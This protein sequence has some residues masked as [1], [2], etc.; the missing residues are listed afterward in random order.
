MVGRIRNIGHSLVSKLILIVAA[1]LLVSIAT[2]S[3]YII[4]YQKQRV[5]EQTVAGVERLANTIRLGT[6]YAMMLNS[7]DD[8]NRIVHNIGLQREIES[9]RVF[10]KDGVIKFS[11]DRSEID[12]ATN[13]KAEACFVC[14]RTSPPRVEVPLD[15]RVRIFQSA[16]GYRLLGIVNPIYNDPACSADPCHVHPPE[17]KVLGAFDVVV[18]LEETDREILQ[19]EHRNLGLAFLVFLAAGTTVFLF[20]LRAVRAPLN[21]LIAGAKRM[22]AGDYTVEVD[23]RQMDEVGEMAT[24]FNHM[25]REIDQKQR[26]LNEQR[27]EYQNLFEQVPCLITVQ[28]RSYRIIKHN[29]LFADT[30]GP[31]PNDYCYHAYKGR[32]QKCDNCPV[33][34]T[35]M[36]GQPVY[37]EQDGVGKDGSPAHW[38][39]HSTPIFNAKGEIVAAMEMSLDITARKQLEDKLE[40]SEKKYHAIFNNIPN[41]VFVLDFDTFE[42]LDCNR[43]V[44]A[45]YDCSEHE[46]KHK[47]FLDLFQDDDKTVQAIQMKTRSVINQARHVNHDG[48]TIFVSI[49]QSVSESEGRKV[50]LVTTN[51]I[52]K[53]LEAEQQL[54]QAGKLAT[55]GEMATGVAHELNQ[56]L[57]VIK[58]VSSFFLK[59]IDRNQAI[60]QETLQTMLRKVD[61]NVDRATKIITHMRLFARKSDV[62]LV[63]TQIN[64][65]LDR[66][67]DIFKQQL[68]VR[69]IEV[70][71]E[72][73]EGLPKIMVDPDRLEQ[74][75]INLLINARDALE[76]KWAGKDHEKR[77]ARITIRTL[78]R[79]GYIRVEVI[80]TGP[81]IPDD[82]VDKI[83][84]P[85][86]TTKEVGKGTGLGLSI[87]Y[88]IVKDCNGSIRVTRD[89]D[90][91][92]RFILEFPIETGKSRPANGR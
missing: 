9:V 71:W 85:F 86:F 78:Q 51:D 76:D 31:E 89:R 5:M 17:K 53:R 37:S 68:K 75:F 48:R 80:D 82:Y 81:G 25:C 62:K 38:I 55:L 47:S 35:F 70:I 79:D 1:A 66:A 4:K 22:T 43:S 73:A 46:M 65:V 11:A 13:I 28:D 74:V 92:A 56:P 33:E 45:V 26:E 24:A 50:L 15:D 41:P 14:H 63:Y 10:N 12:Q 8:I 6:H 60:D 49:R 57:S 77:D 2:W 19:Y 90:G 58:T 3:F 34:L 40:A 52:T 32:D 39:V 23:I 72:A 84:D 59:K 7:R 44:R 69:G 30:F 20:V 91:G 64:D 67:F 29:G 27:N 83:F 87:S 36:T 61:S 21:K 16:S 88:G 54:H 18:S 42:I